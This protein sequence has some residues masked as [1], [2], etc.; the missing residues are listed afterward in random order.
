MKDILI[1]YWSG[2]GNTEKMANL[3]GQGVMESGSKVLIKNV[4]EATIEDIEKFHTIA[5]G[6]PSMGSEVLEECE[7]EPF[8]ES[9]KDKVGGKKIAL[10]GSFGWGDGQWMRDW[11]ERMESYGANLIDEGLIINSE[12]DSKGQ[13]ECI[14]LGKKLV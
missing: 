4:S 8:I 11:V 12:P 6:C 3:I 9:I 2:T 10:F 7:M 5:L 13:E 1:V 14:E